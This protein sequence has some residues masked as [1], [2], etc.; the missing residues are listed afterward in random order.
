MTFISIISLLTVLKLSKLAET[1]FLGALLVYPGKPFVIFSPDHFQGRACAS[2]L[3][4]A[5][6]M[7]KLK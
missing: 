5:V 6:R 1:V 3:C 2:V 7:Y 4:V